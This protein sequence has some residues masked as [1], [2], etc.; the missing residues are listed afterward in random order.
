M[1]ICSLACMKYEFLSALASDGQLKAHS[2]A[3]NQIYSLLIGLEEA[4]GRALYLGL[5]FSFCPLVC[6]LACVCVRRGGWLMD[7]STSC[8]RKADTDLP[9]KHASAVSRDGWQC[10]VF[11][12]RICPQSGWMRARNPPGLKAG[13]RVKHHFAHSRSGR[14][15]ILLKHQLSGRQSL[16][17]LIF[18]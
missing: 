14:A 13:Q 1:F 3:A 12:L 6:A 17:L 2:Q 15:S 4:R 11:R 8:Q 18:L 7:K 9:Q 16:S 5:P 10:F